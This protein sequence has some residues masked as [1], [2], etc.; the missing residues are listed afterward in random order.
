VEAF[1]EPI[2]HVDMDSF[3]VEVERLDDPELIGK[4][5][6]VGGTG[7]RGVI[8]SASYE[9]RAFGVHS[10]MPVGE[11]RRRCPGLIVVGSAHGRYG[12]VSRAVFDVMRSFTP[13]VEGIS[14][15]EAFL[16]VSGR[17]RHYDSVVDIGT[18]V[19]AAIREEVGIPA[20]VGIAS[21]KFMAKIA[22]KHA[23]PDGLLRIV[24]GEETAFLHPLEVGEL[25]GV[26]DA[27][28]TILHDLGIR[29]IGD[30]A[31]TPPGLLE[32]RLGSAAARHLHDLAHARDPRPVEGATTTRSISSEG[33]FSED[34]TDRDTI[35]REVLRMCD[36]VAARLAASRLAGYVVTLKVRF[37]DF[38]TI[39]RSSRREEAVAHTAEIWKTAS[40]LL[41]RAGLAGRPVRLL[42][43]AVGDL[44]D[45]AAARQLV[46]GRE[47]STAA[48]EAVERVRE[49][50]GAGAVIPARI[51]PRPASG[52]RRRPDEG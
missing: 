25:W 13:S 52:E 35:E 42:G 48:A 33:T 36:Q 49:R 7:R 8:A 38:T 6:A 17:R 41:D 5:V 29:T 2:M 11:A 14:I 46:F 1:L 40:A 31:G 22:S 50:F 4:P 32:R 23:K 19:R 3:F 27:T 39:T 20:S 12:E 34:L 10:A 9:A 28:R 37:P 21:T 16:D 18:E 45:A 24:A 15:D 26:G 47:R 51:A 43:I 30:L 44:V